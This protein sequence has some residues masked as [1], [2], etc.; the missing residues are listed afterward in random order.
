MDPDKGVWDNV[1]AS[2][3][4]SSTLSDA[5]PMAG[6]IVV[7][8]AKTTVNE[9]FEGYY[10]GFAD[11]FAMSD[12]SVSGYNSITGVKASK[13]DGELTPLTDDVLNFTLTGGVSSNG[14]I[15][16]KI[17]T[18]YGY[19]LPSDG[20]ATCI[21][22]LRRDTSADNPDKLVYIT[23]EKFVG[24]IENKRGE[25][26]VKNLETT[27]NENSRYVKLFINPLLKDKTQIDQVYNDSKNLV[28]LGA[29]KSCQNLD[30][31]ANIGEL[32]KKIERALVLAENV[33]D[34][35]IDI[36]LDAGLSTIWAYTSASS[37]SAYD[38]AAN[39]LD[40]IK[41]LQDSATGG[42]SDFAQAHRTIFNTYNTFCKDTRKDC[43]HISD[44]IRGIF[45]QGADTKVMS[46]KSKVFSTDIFTPMK[47]L[48][49][50]AN[51]NYACTYANW[52][53]KFDNA[54]SKYVWLPFSGFQAA[55]MA[56]MD[57]NLQPWYAPFGLNNGLISTITDIAVR[58]NQKQNDM[59]YRVGINPV[60]FFTGDG[61]VVWGQKTLQT[62]PS[63]FDR[64]NVRRLFL[65][66]ER[67]TMKVMRYFVGEP[68]TVFTRA[69]VGNVLRPIFDLAKNNEGVY[70]YMVVCDERN[71]TA[72]VID[73]NEMKVDIYIKPVRTAEYILVTFYAT[74]TSQDFNELVS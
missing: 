48:Y 8:D 47:N 20:L 19:V 34:L 66:L 67:A 54:R 60:V 44:P 12:N 4:N 14:S 42:E 50:G 10:I 57:A 71:N 41:S 23:A 38:D 53:R 46:M 13:A 28:S 25:Q 45:V 64:I 9:Y 6:L 70:D 16:E 30:D 35:D 18:S 15:S 29:Y 65:V 26:S 37:I 2:I 32:P 59:F 27:I 36:V 5:T 11:S 39:V 62:K 58:P 1:W 51:S 7:N 33:L 40:D 17:E 74:K 69:R 21:Y 43:I 22:K 61:F 55:I 3:T 56:R 49:N 31:T 52:V 24:T 68:N 72:D 73:N 63:A